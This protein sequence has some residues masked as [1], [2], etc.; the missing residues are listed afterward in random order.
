MTKRIYSYN[1][2]GRRSGVRTDRLVVVVQLLPYSLSP[3]CRA[4]ER[5]CVCEKWIAE[6]LKRQTPCGKRHVSAR[7]Q[8]LSFWQHT[9]RMRSK[10]LKSGRTISLQ[11]R[12]TSF[13]GT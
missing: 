13:I 12:F 5:E 8:E 11:H 10:L 4:K 1:G 6:Q 3:P 9:T 7:R 2:R